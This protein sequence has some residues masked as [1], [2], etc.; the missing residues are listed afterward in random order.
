M[1]ADLA[2]ANSGKLSDQTPNREDDADIPPLKDC[3]ATRET[4][5]KLAQEDPN[6]GV[7][8]PQC[9]SNGLYEEV[10]CHKPTGYCWCVQPRSG[11]PIPSSATQKVRPDCEGAKRTA[12]AFKGEPKAN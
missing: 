4:A 5:I 9:A 2:V 7:F 11:R 12:K 8:I 1:L 10:Q 6:A 3:T